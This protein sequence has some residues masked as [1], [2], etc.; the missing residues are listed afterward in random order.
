M[1][2]N[3]LGPI[4][5]RKLSRG[6]SG[7]QGARAFLSRRYSVNRSETLDQHHPANNSFFN[8][9]DNPQP[10]G[11]ERER[12]S[13]DEFIP[14]PRPFFPMRSIIPDPLSE[15]PTW[16]KTDE[17][18]FSTAAQYRARYPMHNPVGPRRYRNHHL[19]PASLEKR[20]PSVFSPSFPPMAATADRPLENKLPGP[21]RTPSGSPLP[22]P[23]SSQT[24][25]HDVRGRTRK[26]SQT[27]H[28]G[29]D[30]LDVTDPWGTNWHHQSPYDVGHNPE[31]VSPESS[32]VTFLHVFYHHHFSTP[33]HSPQLQQPQPCPG[34]AE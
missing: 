34:H 32:E 22:T 13:L 27:A 33:Y 18:V 25:I 26:L 5:P 31:R 29:V 3:N 7:L 2:K 11:K 20:P 24:R 30:M 6:K 21:S 14:P 12:P 4:G 16:F 19:G 23:S 10:K 9:H 28:D 8:K 15:L 1:D 17:I